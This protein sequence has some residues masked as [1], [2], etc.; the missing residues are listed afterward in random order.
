[1]D[2]TKTYHPLVLAVDASGSMS[3]PV[4]GNKTR[5]E[6]L[7]EGLENFKDE[8]QSEYSPFSDWVEFEIGVISFGKN[9]AV[10]QDLGQ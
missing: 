7:E 4:E 10:D 8:I 6:L 3:W 1:M 5:M 9:V 2:P